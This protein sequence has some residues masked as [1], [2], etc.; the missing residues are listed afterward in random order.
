MEPT[1]PPPPPLSP[2]PEKELHTIESS[3]P[4]TS[5]KQESPKV[6]LTPD[7]AKTNK[8]TSNVGSEANT[9]E[10]K[11]IAENKCLNLSEIFDLFH[12]TNKS[13]SE[14]VSDLKELWKEAISEAESALQSQ[15]PPPPLPP[16]PLPLKSSDGMKNSSN[17][18][19]ITQHK[20]AL[21]TQESAKRRSQVSIP[22]GSSSFAH[23]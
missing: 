2:P 3:S 13:K 17:I 9:K 22:Y 5:L 1:P 14:I 10:E 16:P 15:P 11:S 18:A 20:S 8:P 21:L 7:S 6:E 19:S 23:P 4:S 12:D